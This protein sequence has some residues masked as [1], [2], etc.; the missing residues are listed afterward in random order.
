MIAKGKRLLAFAMVLCLLLCLLPGCGDTA[1]RAA[2]ELPEEFESVDSKTLAENDNYRLDWDDDY[3]SVTLYSQDGEVVWGT[4]P[5]A[6]EQD[7]RTV[8]SPIIIEAANTTSLSSTTAR[9]YNECIKEET[10]SAK[11]IDNGIEVT[12]YFDRFE[13]SVP[14]QFTLR[15]G[16]MAV[17]VDTT[18]VREG[19]GFMLMT[20]SL[21]PYMCSVESIVYP[22]PVEDEEDVDDEEAEDAEDEAEDEEPAAERVPL[23]DAYLFVPSGNGA[24]VSPATQDG[25]RDFT[26]EMYGTDGSRYQPYEYYTPESV[27]MPIFG[28]KD[29]DN[30]L[31]GIMENGAEQGMLVVSAGDDFS[32]VS[33]KFYVRGYDY[34]AKPIN[35][36][37]A[38]N[39]TKRLS[40]SMVD[41]TITVAFY[42]LTGEDANYTGMANKYRDYLIE[43]GMKKS[44][45]AQNAYAVSLLGNVVTT[46]LAFGVPYDSAK[47][48]TT[49]NEAA[50]IIKELTK[51][52]TLNPAVQLV[53]FGK[54][55]LSVGQI[56]GGYGFADVSGSAKEYAALTAY[57][58]EHSIPLFT[59][60]DLVYFK[61]GGNGFTPLF[62]TAKTATLHKSEIYYRMLALRAQ[63]KDT[64]A[65]R[66][67]NRSKLADAIDKL[68]NK[69]DKLSVTGFNLSTLGSV[70]YSDYAEKD[71]EVK[72]GMGEQVQALFATANEAG[73]A[74]STDNAN[75]YAAMVS[76]TLF[77]VEVDPR[78]TD[79]IDMYIP[80]YQMVFKGYIP[81]YSAALNLAD[82]YQ[83]SVLNALASGVGLGYT[84]IENYDASYAATPHTNLY[85][86]QYATNKETINKTVAEYADY[87]KAIANAKIVDYTVLENGVTVTKFDNGVIAYTNP[88]NAEQT[89]GSDAPALMEPMSFQ[90]TITEGGAN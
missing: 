71:Y 36:G 35:E 23:E 64:G 40:K 30:A 51:D 39:G 17:S 52:T 50:D 72:K 89:T 59:D 44:D 27:K 2:Y 80:F 58:E 61:S 82:D 33:A 21:A 13:L 15:D 38:N 54:S 85:S 9:A 3:K 7:D 45:T 66:L 57:A 48:M 8:N 49:F 65:F 90:Y 75:D 53:G 56:A 68:I 16:G 86:S 63:D 28:V 79:A 69:S 11:E 77:N 87:Y 62:N 6:A 26:V 22:T 81:M 37:G 74:V 10:V 24:L 76:D 19:E 20:V 73:H 32:F 43:K 31:L 84:L 42:P 34:Y 1:A 55:G 5:A 25:V 78:Y 83:T 29:G 70:A 47:S 14:V 60:F 12:Y 46:S 67:L 88:T 4:T 41:N 18:K